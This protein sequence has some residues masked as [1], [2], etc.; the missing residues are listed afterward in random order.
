MRAI[1]LFLKPHPHTCELW[2]IGYPR[3]F[4]MV[5]GELAPHYPPFQ[6]LPPSQVT[7]QHINTTMGWN[8]R[9]GW[10]RDG[11]KVNVNST[12]QLGIRPCT[13]I[14]PICYTLYTLPKPALHPFHHALYIKHYS[15]T[16]I[17]PYL[18]NTIN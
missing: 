11:P 9:V 2:N 7:L 3:I 16:Y 12:Y 8:R 17:T 14:K 10:E 15:L 6:T 1:D 18:L 5:G 4:R 13:Y